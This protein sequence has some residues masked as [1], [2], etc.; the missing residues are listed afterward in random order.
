L[1]VTG[2]RSEVEAE[3]AMT[4]AMVV[5][6]EEEE[7]AYGRGAGRGAGGREGYARNSG[8]G[9][10]F[11]SIACV[12]TVGD[13]IFSLSCAQG[14]CQNAPPILHYI[15]ELNLISNEKIVNMGLLSSWLRS[16]AICNI[17]HVKLGLQTCDTR[18]PCHF[19]Y[20]SFFLIIIHVFAC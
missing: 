17:V 12:C 18:F 4:V 1:Q 16:F 11:A 19:G 2:V 15:V 8:R 9:D 13:E 14:K 20:F 3:A 6:G 7:D 5:V 10:C